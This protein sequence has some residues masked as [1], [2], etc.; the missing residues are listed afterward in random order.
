MP[1]TDFL[2]GSGG[3]LDK[4]QK[5]RLQQEL[6]IEEGATYEN[7]L[8]GRLGL[9]GKLKRRKVDP[10]AADPRFLEYARGVVEPTFA[11]ARK[12]IA[13][14][15]A[16]S[17][18]P[19]V[20]GGRTLEELGLAREEAGGI[21]D[22]VEGER[23]AKRERVLRILALLSQPKAPTGGLIGAA[24]SGVGAYFGAKG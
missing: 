11:R 21:A 18:A 5:S 7:L 10:Y 17:D 24:A 20:S 14:K 16:G 19:I 6:D 4:E 12:G 9:F 1:L 13:G 8:P 15:Y 23:R 2:F 22:L 3:G